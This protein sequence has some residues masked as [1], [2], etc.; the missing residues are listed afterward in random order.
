[1]LIVASCPLLHQQ[2]TNTNTMPF[3]LLCQ[4]AT[5]PP[6]QLEPR[7][8]AAANTPMHQCRGAAT[9]TPTPPKLDIGGER[10]TADDDDLARWNHL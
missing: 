6:R 10:G 7:R 2:H 1:M 8:R 5:T 4:C 9:N 3:S